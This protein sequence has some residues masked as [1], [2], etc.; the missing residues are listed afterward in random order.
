MPWDTLPTDC[1]LLASF[2]PLHHSLSLP[3]SARRWAS[4]DPGARVVLTLVPSALTDSVAASAGVSLARRLRALLDLEQ[5]QHGTDHAGDGIGAGDE[6][7]IYGARSGSGSGSGSSQGLPARRRD[8]RELY[9]GDPGWKSAYPDLHPGVPLPEQD[10]ED[11]PPRDPQD[12]EIYDHHYYDDGSDTP[13]LRNH[14]RR[15][16]SQSY[17]T[18]Y[19]PTQSGATLYD[20]PSTYYYSAPA[21]ATFNTAAYVDTAPEP[22]PPTAGG[23]SSSGGGSSGNVTIVLP[24]DDP[25][26][27]D[28][29][30]DTVANTPGVTSA[31]GAW[32][33]NLNGGGE[34]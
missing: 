2:L 18:D 29:Y 24:F 23:S 32:G 6:D 3:T 5:A 8:L 31:V 15:R 28:A 7:E 11:L 33:L 22:Q 9:P 16:L 27:V 21:A 12:A 20:Y 14:H 10:P 13:P 34:W 25:A 1:T 4:S 30:Q 17:V 26:G 19:N